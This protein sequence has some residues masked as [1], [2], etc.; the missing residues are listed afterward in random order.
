MFAS[1]SSQS[2]GR[3]CSQERGESSE[4][5][6]LGSILESFQWLSLTSCR[7]KLG[8]NG[9]RRTQPIPLPQAGDALVYGSDHAL[10]YE[11]CLGCCQV[12]V[13][14]C[15][16]FLSASSNHP[17]GGPMQAH[18]CTHKHSVDSGLEMLQ[19]LKEQRFPSLNLISDASPKARMDASWIRWFVAVCS[20]S[21]VWSLF[22]RTMDP[23]SGCPS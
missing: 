8:R 6:G 11:A 22:L 18:T 12:I 20:A 19:E 5:D 13:R 1:C 17:Q 3:T 16:S 7:S 2:E 23:R 4:P 14:F 10:V 15:I 9:A 21:S